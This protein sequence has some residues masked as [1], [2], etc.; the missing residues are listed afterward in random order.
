MGRRARRCGVDGCERAEQRGNARKPNDRAER[1][2]RPGARPRVS[3]RRRS[4]EVHRAERRGRSERRW[5]RFIANTSRARKDW[6]SV[7]RSGLDSERSTSV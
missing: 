3:Q 2:P 1:C 6:A 4:S 5:T 7:A